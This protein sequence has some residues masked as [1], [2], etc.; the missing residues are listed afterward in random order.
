MPQV[1]PSDDN[2]RSTNWITWILNLAAPGSFGV[3]WCQFLGLARPDL[4]RL[5]ADKYA[6]FAVC[7]KYLLL[8]CLGK[9][10]QAIQKR[11]KL[12]FVPSP[13]AVENI[14]RGRFNFGET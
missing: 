9:F 5:N 12:P 13:N 7:I 1:K 3:V 2:W 6:I 8:D 11:E 10:A 14:R 4:A